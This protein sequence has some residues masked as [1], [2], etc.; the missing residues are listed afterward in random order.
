[1]VSALQSEAP[2][3]LVVESFLRPMGRGRLYTLVNDKPG[4][5]TSSKNS[6][7][8]PTDI[9]R[10]PVNN[11]RLIV[12]VHVYTKACRSALSGTVPWRHDY[13]DRLNDRHKARTI[14]RDPPLVISRHGYPQAPVCDWSNALAEEVS[15]I[16]LYKS[17]SL[18]FSCMLRSSPKVSFRAWVALET[19]KG[20]N[21]R[22][23]PEVS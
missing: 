15:K 5:R 11:A 6:E 8:S 20:L 17:A 12:S 13:L 9:S 10:H 2:A 4:R 1:M 14:A 3:S 23:G 21:N 7:V 19:L 18:F 22:A 16:D